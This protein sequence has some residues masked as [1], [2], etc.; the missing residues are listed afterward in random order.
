M[1]EKR[2]LKSTCRMCHGVCRVNI[3]MEGNRVK[4]ITGD[5]E[6]PTSRGYLCSKGAASVDLLYHPDRILHPLQRKGKRG[7]NQWERISWEDALDQMAE[8]LQAIKRESGS[9]YFAL[10]QGTSRPYTDF[11]SRFAYAFGT[12]NYSG[13]AHVCY[14]PRLMA[15]AFTMGTL[16][17][18]VGDMY[19]FGGVTP[20]CIIIWGSNIT[21]LGAV[22]GMCSKIV[23]QALKKAQKVIVIDPRRTGVAAKADYWLQIRPGTDGA[24]ALAMIHVII[25]EGL[26]DQNFVEKYTVGFQ[27]LAKHVKP[28]TP[29]WAASVTN[30]SEQDIAAVA[31]T[32]AS[33]SPASIQWGNAI[34]MSSCSFHTARSMLILRA[35]TGNID[36]PGGDVF[37]IPPENIKYKSPFL[38][39]EMPGSLLLPMDKYRRAVDSKKA[40]ERLPL[41]HNVFFKSLDRIK[42]RFYNA[43]VRLTEKR[44]AIA[45][46][47]LL[48]RLK[49]PTYPLLP[50]VHPPTFW[51]SIANADP[52]RIR[53]LWIMGSNPLINM[54]NPKMVQK[55]LEKLEYTVVSDLFMTPTAQ[56][57]D[58]F[59]PASTWLEQ[60][61][62]ANQLKLWCVLARKQVVQVG[63][64][65]DDRDVMI[66]LAGRLGLAKAFPWKDYRAFLDDMLADSGIDFEEFCDKGFLAGKMRYR[67]YETEGFPTPSGK[68]ELFSKPL[69][70][71]DV[72]PFPVYREPPVSIRSTPEIAKAYPFTLIGGWK[73]R[74]FFH[75]EG[76]QINLLRKRNPNPLVEIHPETAAS[77]GIKNGD[78]IWVETQNGR[79]KFQTK[80]FDGIDQTVI[81][82]QF[83]WWF[84]EEKAPE[85]A[86]MRSNVNIL[87][88]ETDCDPDC[89]SESL[90]STLCQICKIE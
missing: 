40:N 16:Q 7:E 62:I 56:Y 10:T 67:K 21:E 54:T 12:P 51:R 44:G 65:R 32:Y 2:I 43:F 14:L 30:I 70:Q 42:K 24:L 58:L 36:I 82:A 25:R 29:S 46:L 87:F 1:S 18:P 6:S 61:D 28:F 48:H 76:R 19:G 15:N 60:D 45:R 27:A 22:H 69:A 17:L 79:V 81:N 8:K 13:I 26:I 71:M 50:I 33:F 23:M 78:W 4:K 39:V 73:I 80:C 86:W 66:Q 90:R 68:I 5:A 72:S 41:L 64:G 3:H 11:S 31:K 85:Y 38:S 37:W 55:A 63:E 9:E 89:G 59:L 34:D 20:S 47:K 53:A 84:P 57:A 88:G 74:H 75:S 49:S 35:I 83:G 77:I 52:Y